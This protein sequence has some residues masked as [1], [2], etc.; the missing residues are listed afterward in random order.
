[1][2]KMCSSS[3]NAILNET[4]HKNIDWLAGWLVVYKF[5]FAF[6]NHNLIQVLAKQRRQICS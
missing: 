4:N 5:K 6:S 1:M 2:W 3:E